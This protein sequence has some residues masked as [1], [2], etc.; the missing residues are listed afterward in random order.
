[1]ENK[2]KSYGQYFTPEKIVDFMCNT[3]TKP[4]NATIL[5]PAAGKGIFVSKLLEL[6]FSNITAYEIDSSLQNETNINFHNGNFL[7]V[8]LTKQYDVIIGNPPYVSWKNIPE[9]IKKELQNSIYWSD[10]IKGLNDL[11]HAFIYLSID[12]LK[13]NGELIFITPSYWLDTQYADFIRE[14][15]VEEGILSYL[16]NFNEMPIF[17]SIS[18][19]L[20]IF[21]FI[22]KKH[23]IPI[24]IIDFNKTEKLT[25]EFPDVLLSYLRKLDEINYFKQ[26]NKEA[27]TIQQF[28]NGNPW[29]IISP[30][31][32][33]ILEKIENACISNTPKIKVNIDNEI[34]KIPISKLFDK[35][36]L[37]ELNISEQSCCKIRFEN[38]N[39]FFLDQSPEESVTKGNFEISRYTRLG[40]ISEIG[41]GLVSGMDSAFKAESRKNFTAIEK[42][43]LIP[44]IRAKEIRKFFSISHSNY[45]FVNDI[46][47]ERELQEKYPNIFSKLNN[48]KI[49]LERRYNYGRV[50]PWWHWVF[51][52]NKELMENNEEKIFVPCRERFDTKNY[53]RFSYVKGL[54]YGTQD[55]T[56]IVKKSFF[57]ES[58]KYLLGILNSKLIFFWLKHKGVNKGG[59]LIF[60]E[61][62]LAMIPIKLI[63]WENKEEVS[64][65]NEIVKKVETILTNKL[66]IIYDEELEK[67]V[68]KLYKIEKKEIL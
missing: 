66:E 20:I 11:L 2:I 31:V 16:V 12:L 49:T 68:R 33:D 5:E 45:I 46:K 39:Y 4:K 3:I 7:S 35:I 40:D 44:V 6:G 21:K 28:S 59:V 34:R 67:L 14:K 52:R 15:I 43:K 47:N 9:K 27:F 55:V 51:L 38:K 53:I 32:I 54:F 37:N 19:S 13:E 36:D 17:D 8:D 18:S 57:S 58:L 50:I 24:K 41:N 26:N 60:S 63:D 25:N 22:K 1:M 23:D 10:T 61:R 29:K 65:H 48:D 42:T 30:L 62:P 64:I 56:V